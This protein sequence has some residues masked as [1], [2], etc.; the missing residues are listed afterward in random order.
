V[1]FQIRDAVLPAMLRAGYAEVLRAPIVLMPTFALPRGRVG[2]R[3]VV[4][5]G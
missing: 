2:G 3:E 5:R 1:A 4:V